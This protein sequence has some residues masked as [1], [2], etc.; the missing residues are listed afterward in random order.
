[1]IGA[2]FQRI[3]LGLHRRTFA[4]RLRRQR[5]FPECYVVSVGNLSTGGTGKTPVVR[6]LVRR[7]LHPMVVLRGYGGRLSGKGGL[8]TDGR[9]TRASW[10]ESGDEA[11]LYAR[12]ADLRVAVGRNRVDVIER[13]RSGA[14][15]IFLDDAFQ[16]PSVARDHDLVLV[17]AGAPRWTYELLPSGRMREPW[18][19]LARADTVLLTRVNQ[20]APDHLRWLEERIAGFVPPEAVFRSDHRLLPLEPPL[21]PGV[22][23]G[24]FCGI[25]NP[26]S[27]RRSLAEAGIK[28]VVW[29][30]F[31]DHHRYSHREVAR[32]A[33]QSGE[34]GVVWVTTEKDAVRL[35]GRRDLPAEFLATLH[36][37]PVEIQIADGREGEFLSKVLGPALIAA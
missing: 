23:V 8:V 2:F 1:M 37:L 12:T 11:L 36:V 13:Y 19:A 4:R 33:A 6:A 29:Q 21:P 30:E 24:A 9:S 17:D 32:L 27:F 16:N 7:T 26:G 18:E 5:R 3:Y 14:R 25:G 15:T 20:A 34:L 28:P 10:E 31:A 22:R 35:I